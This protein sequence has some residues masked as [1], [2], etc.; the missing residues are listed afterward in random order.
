MW[1]NSWLYNFYTK[2][3]FFK[4]D[5]RNILENI[6]IW[7]S[8]SILEWIG[9]ALG[10]MLQ[11]D[12]IGADNLGSCTRNSSCFYSLGLCILERRERENVFT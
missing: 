9:L 4:D 1:N 5:N 12:C 10:C 11:S 2:T 7:R 8:K 6:K 3:N